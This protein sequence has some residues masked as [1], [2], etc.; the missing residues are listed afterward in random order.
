VVI[1]AGG[2]RVV[3]VR[4]GHAVLVD[5]GETGRVRGRRLG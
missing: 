3:V 1:E 4:D 5:E 2:R